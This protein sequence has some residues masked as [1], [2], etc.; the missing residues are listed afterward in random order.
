MHDKTTAAHSDLRPSFPL[1]PKSTARSGSGNTDTTDAR[2]A[3]VAPG[4]YHDDLPNGSGLVT[5]PED[6]RTIREH[7]AWQLRTTR[8]LADLLTLAVRDG[9]PRIGWMVGSVG[10]NLAGH[11]YGRTGAD[12]RREFEAWCAAVAATPRPEFTNSSGI[13]HLRAIVRDYDGLV[14]IVVLAAVYPDDESESDR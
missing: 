13:T 5:P 9:L 6:S 8:V 12:R 3:I 4:R 11:C 14:D 10:A 2:A 7:L 1:P